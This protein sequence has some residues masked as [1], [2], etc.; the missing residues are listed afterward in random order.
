MYIFILFFF[1]RLLTILIPFKNPIKPKDI[2]NIALLLVHPLKM[3]IALSYNSL[4][5]NRIGEIILNKLNMVKNKGNPRLNHPLRL[6]RKLNL[7][8]WEIDEFRC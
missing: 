1:N 5:K 6:L 3:L 4:A 2:L 8:V 7:Y